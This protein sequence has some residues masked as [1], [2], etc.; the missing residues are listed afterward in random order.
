MGSRTVGRMRGVAI[1]ALTSAIAALGNGPSHRQVAAAA[2]DTVV[3]RWNQVLLQAIGE[4]RFA[5]T[6]AARALAITHTCMYDAWAAYDRVA[7]GVHWPMSLRRPIAE[8]TGSN[9]AEAI[10]FA[11][12]AALVDLFPSQNAR[13][14]ALLGSLGYSTPGAAGSVGL[15]SC[16]AVLDFR[17][18][19][20]SNQLGELHPG[21]YSDYTG[22]APVNTVDTIHDPNRW[23]PLATAAGPQRFLTPH[24]G[25]VT[26]FALTSLEEVRP[27]PPPLYPHG[28]YIQE[29]NQILHFSAKLDDR[30][31]MIAEY[32]ADGPASA[33]PPGHWNL[34]AQAVSRRDA[35]S[36][37]DDVKMF[38]ALGNAVLDAS[39]AVWDCKRFF[40][41]TR[42][43]TAIRFLYGG[44]PVRAWAGPGLGTRLMDGNQ[45]RSYIPTPPFAEYVSGHSAFS[46][47]SAE[48]LTSFT[49][50]DLFGFSVTFAPGSSTIEP[51]ITPARPIVLSWATYSAAADEA[52]SSRRLGGIHFQSGD[53]FARS[54]GRAVG[55]LVWSRSSRFFD[56]SFRR[57]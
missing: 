31:K 30:S 2:T 42:P 1:V 25:L 27:A 41:F 21:A 14:D 55:S 32:W 20:G 50:S 40:D 39:I 53:L 19:D 47:A 35:H 37:D 29:A 3:V 5:P 38:F 52:A 49:R 22:Y 17:H 11:A 13:F 56:G 18:G 15:T 8:H 48:I 33:T 16:Q 36:L 24:W 54:L 23:Q 34:F 43:V 26:P 9:K 4:T 6:L 46:A 51:G 45:F 10:S 12:H 7:D 44:K 57:D 28:N